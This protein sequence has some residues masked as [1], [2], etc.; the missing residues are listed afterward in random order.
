M[1]LAPSAT[2]VVVA[3][4]QARRIVGV[5]RYDTAPEVKGL[6]SV[7]GFLDPSPEAVVALR[8]DLALWVTDG[9]AFPTIRKVAELGVPV[10]ALPVVGVEDVISTARVVGN[11]LG[12]ASAGELLAGSLEDA[13]GRVRA[14]TAGLRRPRALLVVGREPLVVAGPGSYPDELIRIAGAEN[15]VKG[16][17]PWPV[18]PL[19]KALADDPDV[20][21]DAAYLEH[22]GGEGNLAAIPAA[23][24]GR[25]VKLADDDVLR[26]GPR[27]VRALDRLFAAVHPE[28]TRR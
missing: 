1:S 11:A 15:V 17:R 13:I 19:E 21:I 14:R 6:P 8:P 9:G 27:L 7:G 24:R 12:D 2:D 28:A 10:L 22:A 16:T 18:Y 26:P 5:T 25:L 23:R 20:V 3:L 4:G